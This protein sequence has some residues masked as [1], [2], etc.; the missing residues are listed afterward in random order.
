MTCFPLFFSKSSSSARKD[1]EIDEGNLI[2]YVIPIKVGYTKKE[3]YCFL[4]LFFSSVMI[5]FLNW[6]ICYLLSVI[7]Y[8]IVS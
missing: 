7:C 6:D 4:N 1:P 8:I 2:T 5:V 3:S